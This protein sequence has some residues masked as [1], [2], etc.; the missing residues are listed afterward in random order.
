MHHYIN[1]AISKLICYNNFI[2]FETWSICLLV[3][4]DDD[5]TAIDQ[6]DIIWYK[7][8]VVF[9][10]VMIFLLYK[11]N[12]NG[13]YIDFK[14]VY[15]VKCEKSINSFID[16]LCLLLFKWNN[17]TILFYIIKYFNKILFIVLLL[18]FR[19]KYTN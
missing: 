14:I 4:N 3:E 10:R 16:L 5:M 19:Y 15:N 12:E 2:V 1:M 7:G 13:C 9:F 11:N 6:F 8:D 17:S 18:Y